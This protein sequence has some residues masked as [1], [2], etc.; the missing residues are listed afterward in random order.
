[1]KTDTSLVKRAM[2]NECKTATDL[3]LYIKIEK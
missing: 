1:M 3:A 2:A